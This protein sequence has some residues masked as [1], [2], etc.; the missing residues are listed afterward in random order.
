[1]N[2][3]LENWEHI[4]AGFGMLVALCTAIVKMTPTQKDDNILAKV[5]KWA[6]VFSIVFTKKDAQVIADALKKKTK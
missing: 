1:M 5:V 2:W 3:L 4:A 6:D